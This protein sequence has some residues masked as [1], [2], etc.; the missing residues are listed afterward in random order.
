MDCQFNDTTAQPERF[1]DILPAD[2]QEEIVPFWPAYRQTARIYTLETE[3]EILG[4]GIVFASVSPD[5]KWYEQEAQSW[6]DKKYLYI[7]FLWI[8]EKHRGKSLGSKWLSE[9]RKLFPRQKFWLSIEE[10]G[11]MDFY[12]KNGFRIVKRIHR[13]EGE[14]WIMV[15][16]G[17]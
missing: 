9:L 5:T 15:K 3:P 2:W 4:G 14:E 10:A 16:E 13:D 7:G 6:F 17:A 8:A 11:L 12:K 1:F